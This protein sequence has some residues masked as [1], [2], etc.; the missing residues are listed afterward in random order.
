M[1]FLHLKLTLP[2]AS[3]KPR[4]VN[5]NTFI[6]MAEGKRSHAVWVTT[7]GCLVGEPTNVQWCRLGDSVH[8]AVPTWTPNRATPPH[9]EYPSTHSVT[10]GAAAVCP[11][12]TSHGSRSAGLQW[13]YTGPLRLEEWFH[14][15]MT[16]SKSGDGCQR[17]QCQGLQWPAHAKLWLLR[18]CITSRL[19][20]AQHCAS[21]RFAVAAWLA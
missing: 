1:H 7:E 16:T 19:L 17:V 9:P 18:H 2:R 14:M 8:A 6:N 3:Q 21:C 4:N 5:T 11:A 20:P 10:S 12:A 13:L 15:T